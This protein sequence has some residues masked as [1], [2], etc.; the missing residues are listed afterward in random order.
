MGRGGAGQSSK[1]EFDAGEVDLP[2]Y[3]RKNKSHADTE[4]TN[5]GPIVKPC[6]DKNK[7]KPEPASKASKGCKPSPFWRKRGRVCIPWRSRR[8]QAQK[9]KN[10]K[11]I[12][13][14]MTPSK[15]IAGKQDMASKASKGRTHPFFVQN[16]GRGYASFPGC[17]WRMQAKT[18]TKST[19]T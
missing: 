17:P 11:S 10:A 3:E 14:Y 2:A 15:P 4:K 7:D 13:T 18:K 12:R 8:I 5:T 9:N 19:R 6:T 1:R 16:G